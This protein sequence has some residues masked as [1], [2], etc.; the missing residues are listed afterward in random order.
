MSW[1]RNI[2]KWWMDLG[3][4]PNHKV[5]YKQPVVVQI[6]RKEWKLVKD[7]RHFWVAEDGKQYQL[8][9]HKG[10]IYDFASIPRIFWVT[11]GSPAEYSRDSLVHDVIYYYRGDFSNPHPEH[12]KAEL[13]E[14]SGD[15]WVPS[16]KKF[17]I[18][19]ID[20]KYLEMLKESGVGGINRNLQFWAVRVGGHWK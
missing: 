15:E 9:I 20:R 11:M 4:N 5:P 3:A 17:T 14:K 7:Y 13:F 2:K 16:N 10:T 18:E 12:A 1:A 6:S 8:L 19:E